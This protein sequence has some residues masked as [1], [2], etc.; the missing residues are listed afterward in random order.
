MGAN[1]KDELAQLDTVTLA[2]AGSVI[3]HATSNTV[4]KVRR[5]TGTRDSSGQVLGATPQL[6]DTDLIRESEHFTRLKSGWNRK[7]FEKLFEN[8]REVRGNLQPIMIRPVPVVGKTRYEVV[9]GHR[10]LRACSMAGLKVLVIVEDLSAADALLRQATENGTLGLKLTPYEQGLHYQSA[11]AAKLFPS[12]RKLADALRAD[13]SR[14][15]KCLLLSRLP[16]M[17]LNVFE[18]RGCIN[19][20]WAHRLAKVVEDDLEE[21]SKRIRTVM[22]QHPNWLPKQRF[23]YLVLGPP[24]AS[25]VESPRLLEIRRED[26]VWATVTLPPHSARED[27]SVIFHGR[28]AVDEQA[29]MEALQDLEGRP[30]Q[31]RK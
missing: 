17:V 18:D 12:A 13:H 7:P 16:E 29:L 20:N 15:S 22:E 26:K 4:E 30:R 2:Q 19:M 5:L 11:L 8:I 21:L 28:D 10:R 9:Y 6:I 31:N 14:V 24:N 23:E 3:S 25:D 1:F 27:V